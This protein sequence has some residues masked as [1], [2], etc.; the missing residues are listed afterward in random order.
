MHAF[1]DWVYSFVYTFPSPEAPSQPATPT[2]SGHLAR[3]QHSNDSV[4]SSHTLDLHKRLASALDTEIYDEPASEPTPIQLA[5][6]HEP[7][8]VEAL[9]RPTSIFLPVPDAPHR[10][11]Y[12]A[13]E[14]PKV[15]D[16]RNAWNDIPG[17]AYVLELFLSGRMQEAED[18]C[19]KVDPKSYVKCHNVN[20]GN[21]KFVRERMYISMALGCIHCLKGLMSF[22]DEDLIQAVNSNKHSSTIAAQHRKKALS[23]TTRFY[24]AAFSSSDQTMAHYSSMTPSELHSELVYAESL[25]MKVQLFPYPYH[26]QSCY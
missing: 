12:V 11:T 6:P 16:R 18:W 19:Q 3:R 21:S 8:P 2:S 24:G 22:A 4:I 25:C 13:P 5:S 15:Y 7:L 26:L 9:A 20:P 23:I 1:L 14:L 17:V 10:C